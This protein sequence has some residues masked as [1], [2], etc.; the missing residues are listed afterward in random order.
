MGGMA[1]TERKAYASDFSDAKLADRVAAEVLRCRYLWVRELDW[2]RWDSTRWR[3][4]PEVEVVEAVRGW[5][6]AEFDAVSKQVRTGQADPKLL[7]QHLPLLGRAKIRAIVE[8]TRGIEGVLT[9]A[10]ALDA[11]PDLINTPNCVVDL[12][13][14]AT[15]AHDPSLLLTKITRGSYR[16]G[17]T[18]PD[19]DTAL[20][21]LDP[22]ERAWFQVV[23]GQ[24]ITGHRTPD[25]RLI[26]MLGSGANGKGAITTDGLLPALGDY[27]DVASPKLFTGGKND[28]TTERADL[29]GTR[30]LVA[31]ELAEQRAINVTA[32][33]QV[34]DVGRIKARK[35]YRDNFT[36]TASHSLLATSNYLPVVAETD[37]GTWRRLGLLRFRYTYVAPPA[38]AG[39]GWVPAGEHE[40]RGDGQLKARIE[41]G[42]DQADAAVTWAVEGA[43]RSYAD[44]GAL[45]MPLSVERD[46][47]AWRTEAD[48]VLGFW[49]ERLIADLE[50]CIT[51]K[52]LLEAFNAWL[53][54][55][56]HTPWPKEL[57]GSRFGGHS[58][59]Q[60]H[61]LAK[62]RTMNPVGLSRYVE[63]GLPFAPLPPRPE[64]WAGVR[65][66]AA[67]DDTA[68]ESAAR[69]LTSCPSAA[70]APVSPAPTDQLLQRLAG[71]SR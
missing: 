49:S 9:E 14:E 67:A 6:L 21:A 7:A 64:V 50:A 16:A 47:L 53:R 18:H 31:E 61:R 57:F 59:T 54:E 26:V 68:D 33:K 37:D 60:R 44:P 30:L 5:V 35:V 12:R 15:Y 63:P 8:L 3:T 69:H 23:I 40:R 28:H 42:Q 1:V 29:R 52:E 10:D 17:H 65:F 22:A 56:G 32:L 70:V 58:E 46:T 4:V 27:A 34:Q 41:T 2:H 13:T 39:T 48:R 20:G 43:R 71:V 24:G 38:G 36:F 51:S 19:W 66:R 25:G 62:R 45:A 11:W 55:G